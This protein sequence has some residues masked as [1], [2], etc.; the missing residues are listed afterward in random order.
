M[1]SFNRRFVLLGTATLVAGCG[2]APAYGPNGAANALQG[3][4]A[5]DEPKSRPAYLLTQELEGRLGRPSPA[6]YGLAYSI[7]L[8]EDPI[9]ISASNVTSRFNLLGR[10]TFALRDLGTGEVLTSGKVSNFTSY[11]ASGTTVA[12]QA[13]ERDAEERLMVILA[14]QITTRLIAA[15]GSLPA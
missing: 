12:T 2:F 4:I 7:T 15:S 1:S 9:A 14:D 8:D 11:S 6:R 10:V 5:V 13:A 3:A